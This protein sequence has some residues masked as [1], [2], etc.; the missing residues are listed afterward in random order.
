MIVVTWWHGVAGDS[1]QRVLG[2]LNRGNRVVAVD[3]V[4]VIYPFVLSVGV[5]SKRRSGSDRR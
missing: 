5:L 3:A 1:R 4:I 2:N